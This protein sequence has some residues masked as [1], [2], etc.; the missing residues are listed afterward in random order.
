MDLNM[1]AIIGS[2]IGILALIAA[3][4]GL[5]T[6]DKRRKAEALRRAK[7]AEKEAQAKAA[8]RAKRRAKKIAQLEKALE[9]E[10]EERERYEQATRTQV[11]YADLKATQ[12]DA[13]GQKESSTIKEPSLDVAAD[14]TL[15]T[16]AGLSSSS[17][18]I[19]SEITTS[20]TDA[21]ISPD[22]PESPRPDEP[23]PVES[24]ESP[25]VPSDENGATAAGAPES[26]SISTSDCES[27][28]QVTQIT[29]IVNEVAGS[30]S[31][32]TTDDS[33]KSA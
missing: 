16:A 11:L 9:Q 20:S 24:T 17:E 22:V 28:A 29:C 31:P 33:S 13:A 8:R 7:Q 25:A 12:A 10:R 27:A 32:G 3:I 2:I 4:Y 30:P 18:T 6:A 23:E 21:S 5:H 19:V 14:A 15:V 1:S 26:N